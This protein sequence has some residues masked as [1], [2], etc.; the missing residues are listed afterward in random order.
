MS[1]TTVDFRTLPISIPS[2]CI[3]RVFINIDETRI[4]R[5]FDE[6]NIGIIDRIDIICKTTPKGE[7]FNRVYVHFK[8]WFINNTN[9]DTA[10]ERLLNGK[11]IKIIYDDPW[12]WKVSAYRENLRSSQHLSQDKK[13]VS[14]QFYDDKDNTDITIQNLNSENNNK[15]KKS[16]NNIKMINKINNSNNVPTIPKLKR[17]IAQTYSS[18]IDT[19]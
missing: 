9:A 12:F 7:K 14:L 17:N 10:R 5:V 16:S 3:P 6:L 2:L 13:K 1:T 8:R 4:R 11:D 19:K 18:K 15:F